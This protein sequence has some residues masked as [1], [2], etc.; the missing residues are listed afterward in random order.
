MQSQPA[1]RGK[2]RSRAAF[3]RGPSDLYHVMLC[4]AKGQGSRGAGEMVL[5]LREAQHGPVALTE[6]HL[7]LIPFFHTKKLASCGAETCLGS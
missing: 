6:T 2:L 3:L 5:V 1:G 7:L 4:P